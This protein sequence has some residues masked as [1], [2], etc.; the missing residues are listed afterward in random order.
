M[1][2]KKIYMKPTQ[3]IIELKACQT[4]LAGSVTGSGAASLDWG[5]TG[6][7]EEDGV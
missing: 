1:T 6:D 4:L 5:G 3:E 2:M 7:P